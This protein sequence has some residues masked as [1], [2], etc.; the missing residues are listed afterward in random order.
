MTEITDDMI[1]VNYKVCR[2]CRY[3]CTYDGN[4]YPIC[5][6]YLMTGKRRKCPVGWCNHYDRLTDGQR[7]KKKKTIDQLFIKEDTDEW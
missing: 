4:G 5:D 1:P 7:R 2:T 3:S 6:Y